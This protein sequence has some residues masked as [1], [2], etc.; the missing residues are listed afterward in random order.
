MELLPKQQEA[1]YFLKDKETTEIFYGGAAGGGKSAIGCLWLIE[2]SQIHAGSRWLMGRSKLK[3]LKET[4]LNT[5][6]EVATNLGVSNQFNYNSQSGTIKFTNG[7]EIVLKDLFAY[8]SDPN[9][10]ELGSLEITGAFID[11]APQITYK[12]WQMV[13][14]RIRYKLNEFDKIPKILGTGNPSKGWDYRLFYKAQKEATKRQDRVFIQALPTDNHFLPKSYLDSLLSLD[15]NSKQRL[16]YGNYEYDDDPTT[17]ITYDKILEV[18]TNSHLTEVKK[19]YITADI[20]RLGSDKA[21]IMVWDD[22]TVVE[23]L[24]FDKSRITDLQ[25]AI[26]TFQSR[27]QIPNSRVVA[28]EDGVGGGL[29]DNLRIIGF[30]NNSKALKDENYQNLQTQC[31][32]KMAEKVQNNLLWIKCDVSEK[33]KDEIIQELEQVKTYKMDTDGKLR[34][35][36]K[37][38]IKQNIGR[39]PDYRD[40]LM[41][42]ALF[43]LQPSGVYHVY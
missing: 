15:E 8:P 33:T 30:V 9:F 29:I 31:V 17:L 20:A 35:L 37:E 43:D 16:Y 7:S 6:F 40:T 24:T 36:P 22:W 34:L 39:S 19:Y 3:T 25:L 13:K 21:V 27:Y 5:F 1:V 38:Q 41:M 10:D 12:C 4:T 11:E 26:Q 42:R 18:F 2:Q 14:S 32:Y 23:I 28:D